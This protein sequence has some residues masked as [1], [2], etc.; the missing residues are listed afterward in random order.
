MRLLNLVDCERKIF[1]QN[2]EDGII[3]AIFTDIGTTNKVVVEFGCGDAVECNTAN[4]IGQGW[5]GL[6]MDGQHR[7]ANPLITIKN[8]FISAENIRYLFQKHQV[9]E[10]FDLLSIDIDGNDLWV[11]KQITQRPRVV[12]SE[13]NANVPVHLSR[14]ISYDPNFKWSGTDYFGASLLALKKMGEL[15][16]YTLIYCESRGVNAFFV[17]NEAL[18]AGYVPRPIE[19]IYRPPNYVGVGGGWPRDPERQMIDPY[20]PLDAK[21][22]GLNAV[23][24]RTGKS[25]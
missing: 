23:N 20:R 22:D 10:H 3:E 12:I 4:L 21:Q 5:T 1:S 13:Y 11:W 15:K 17:A 16:G 14:A 25:G 9:P 18:P 24:L 8:E 6:H 7:S 2:G 19:E